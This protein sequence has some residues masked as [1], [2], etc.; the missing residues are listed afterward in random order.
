MGIV[1]VTAHPPTLSTVGAP[2]RPWLKKWSLLCSGMPAPRSHATGSSGSLTLLSGLRG[3]DRFAGFIETASG[4]IARTDGLLLR[5]LR[6]VHALVLQ[7]C[8]HR[9]LP[10]SDVSGGNYHRIPSNGL[11]EALRFEP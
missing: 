8:G 11:L 5:D 6:W 4:E 1:Y 10:C 9:D 3:H 2:S 7:Q